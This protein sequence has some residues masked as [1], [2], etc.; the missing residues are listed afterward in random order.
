MKVYV[1]W[2]KTNPEG[3][4]E[5]DIKQSA[6]MHSLP[7]KPVPISSAPVDNK[8]GWLC[9]LNCQGIDFSGYD[10][11]A[12]E[13]VG[14]GL[15]IIGWQDDTEDFGDTRWAVEWTLMPPAPDPTLGG[16]VNTV[17]MRRIW[18]TADAFKWF[19]GVNVLPWEQFI[20]PPEKLTFHGVWLPDHLYAAHQK[21]R[22]PHGWR[23]WIQ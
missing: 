22:V 1:Q 2:S 20:A 6:Q 14:E 9:G 23:E 7:K 16:I 8:P 18:A 10:H 12:I 5:L 13:V 19:P 11:T 15:R 3:W 17:Q 4:A 21:A